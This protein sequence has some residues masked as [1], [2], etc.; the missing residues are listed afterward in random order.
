MKYRNRT[1]IVSLI[2]NSVVNEGGLDG[3]TK[4][5]IIHKAFL[6]YSQL[7]EYLHIVTKNN[8]L[9]Y[10]PLMKKFKIT[11][12]GIQFLKVYDKLEKSIKINH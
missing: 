10:D 1:E 12:K 11:Q 2:L 8:L 3:V 4:T 7:G 5:R 6:S 9:S